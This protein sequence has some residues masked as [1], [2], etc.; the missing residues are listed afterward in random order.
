MSN[1]KRKIVLSGQKILSSI[2]PTLCSKWIYKKTQGKKLNLENPQ[3]F[4][5]KLMWLKLK[6][7]NNNELVTECADK[8]MVRNYIKSC[9]CEE[10]LNE[11]IRVYDNVDDINFEELPNEFV[12]K[13]NHAAGYNIIC[14]NKKELDVLETK[15]QLK[16]WLK[17]DYWK[18]YAEVNYKNIHKKIICEK[19][20]E[21]KSK[22]D[23]EDYK[24]Y[25]F[26]GKAQF[27]MICIGRNT[28]EKTQYY[29]MD[30]D[31]KIMKINAYGLNAPE[32]LNIEKP[33]NIREMFNYAEKLS[34]T[35]PFVRVDLYNVD[36][37]IYFG[38]LTFTPAGCVDNKYIG[39]AQKVLG[40]MIK[41]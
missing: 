32:N 31:W 37:K 17:D 41:L 2:S 35:F 28:S 29:F 24:F 27:V 9:G 15:K 21:N 8:Y 18:Q 40:D 10:I 26:N 19:Y 20:L 30:K 38:E 16:K 13:C 12:L 3:L 7:Y 23:L 22:T 36:G 33:A 1:V 6:K 4:N 11:I 5:E 34:K 39:D 14:K 25:C